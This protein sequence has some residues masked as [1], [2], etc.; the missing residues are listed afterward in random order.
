MTG[1]Y[2]FNIDPRNHLVCMELHGFFT[3]DQM[4]GFDKARREAYARLRCAP[5]EHVTLV[6][7]RGTLIQSQDIVDAFARSI[8]DQGTKSRRI[9]FVVSRS[10]AR[11]QV[12]RAA[13]DRD[14]GYFLTLEEAQEWLLGDRA[15]AA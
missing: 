6:D 1:T 8:A 4:P 13:G 15:E 12:K 14:A 9:A 7:M 5:N 2:S 3:P 10:L 11:L